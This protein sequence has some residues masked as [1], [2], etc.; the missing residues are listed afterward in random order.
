[1]DLFKRL[2]EEARRLTTNLLPPN[3]PPFPLPT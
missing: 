1:M 2:E 3:D